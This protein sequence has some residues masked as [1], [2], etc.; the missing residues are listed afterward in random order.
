[1]KNNIFILLGFLGLA[2]VLS[3]C[4]DWLQEKNFTKIGS[5]YIYQNEDGLKVGLNGLYNMQRTYNRVSDATHGNI[6]FY[7]AT[8]LANVRTWN[9]AQV[10][11]SNMNPQ[12]MPAEEWKDGYQLIDRASALID[13][14]RSVDFAVAADKSKLIAE[15]K[16]IRAMTY[17]KIWRIYDNILIDTIPTTTA[18]AFDPVVYKPAKSSDVLNLINSDLDY[19]IAHL[20]YKAR[21][22][23][24]NQALAR[25]IRAKVAAWQGDWATMAAQCDSVIENGGYSLM[26]IDQVFAQD[27]NHNE[28][29]Y[30]YQFDETLGGS[31][32]LAGGGSHVLSALFTAR[33]YEI[34]GG[35]M[36]QD[37][38]WG[39]NSY[40]WTTPNDYLKSLYNVDPT[41]G[42]SQDLRFTNYYYPDTVI[43]N[44]P[45][46]P[47]FGK[48]LPESAYPDNYRQYHWSIMKYRDFSK[49]DTRAASWKDVIAVR[50]AETYLLGAEA[51]WRM[52]NDPSD[53]TALAYI[54]KVRERA[55]VPDLLSID[56]QTILDEN[57][58]ELAFEGQRW[59]L[60]KRE[61]VLVDQ[62]DKYH[63]YGSARTN[64]IVQ[65]MKDYQVRWPIPQ[66]QID[67]MGPD[68]PQNEGY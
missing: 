29:I 19:A 40:A 36:I 37:N 7:C 28:A 55:G 35:Y 17:F 26:P 33:Y 30:T 41:T 60:L 51:H 10:Y 18:N 9:D 27:V 25:H 31:N 6:W 65:G 46:N 57:A 45:A 53:P 20:P 58:R 12:A 23:E 11:N 44:N 22:G 61:G 24:V 48:P 68:F 1:M 59:F 54:N 62:V 50:L 34:P 43:C 8:D 67:L 13:G 15:A 2:A 39:G 47:Y 64:Q 52:T 5:E 42:K 66:D 4:N 38:N 14:A 56:L 3:S 32:N 16:V 49:P 63:T 21:P